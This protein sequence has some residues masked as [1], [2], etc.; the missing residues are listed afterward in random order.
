MFR[1]WTSDRQ[2]TNDR[3]LGC[4]QIQYMIRGVGGGALDHKTLIAR[5]PVEQRAALQEKSNLPGMAR[6]IVH[7]GLIALIG[8]LIAAGAAGWQLLMVVQGVLIIFC[9][10]LLH[11]TTHKT[12]FASLRLNEIVMHVCAFLVLLPPEWFR[13]FHLAHHRYTNDPER[14]PELAGEKASNWAGYLWRITGIPVWREHVSQ[15]LKNAIGPAN[16]SFLPEG[17]RV[18]VLAEARVMVALYIGVGIAITSGQ[19]WLFWCWLGPALLGQPFL[20]LY[21]MAEHGRCPP[22]ANM[23]E[24]TR[25]TFTNRI[26]RWIAWNMPYHAE[27]HAFPTVPFHKLP[28]LH[29]IAKPHLLKTSNGYAGFHRE[30]V[31]DLR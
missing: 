1:I 3:R 20:R 29:Q 26:I 9:F 7:W 25:T 12:P 8:W 27:H 28:D 6:L 2:K 11:E 17:R 23:L 24:N 22:V 30:Y 19:G 21:L 13:Y 15:I 18:R 16:D 31:G 5:L 4:V 14:D 10:T